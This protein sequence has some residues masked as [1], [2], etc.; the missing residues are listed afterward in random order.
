[1]S[2]L[3]HQQFSTVQS[4]KQMPPKTIASAA[5]IAL[6]TKLTFITGTVAIANIAPPVS[7]YVEVTLVFTDAAP[8]VLLTT[9]NVQFA[10]APIQNRA[11]DLCW[12]PSSKKWWAKAT[13]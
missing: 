7:G 6:S 9:G 2:D 12:D 4:D 3:D 1:M 10:Y 5:D 13:V 11:I 8:A